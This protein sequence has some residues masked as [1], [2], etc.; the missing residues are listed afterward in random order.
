MKN[1]SHVRF[2]R[3]GKR[4]EEAAFER[5]LIAIEKATG[6]LFPPDEHRR[7]ATA[8]MRSTS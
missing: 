3:V 7:I 4:F 1:L 6:R 5:V 8:R 2:G